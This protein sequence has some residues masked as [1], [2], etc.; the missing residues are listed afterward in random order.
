[1]LALTM[2][3]SMLTVI[4]LANPE[5]ADAATVISEFV[6]ADRTVELPSAMANLP[7]LDENMDMTYY[8]GTGTGTDYY[9]NDGFYGFKSSYSDSSPYWEFVAKKGAAI[10]SATGVSGSDGTYYEDYQVAHSVTS[11]T[12]FMTTAEDNALIKRTFNRWYGSSSNYLASGTIWMPGVDDIAGHEKILGQVYTNTASTYYLRDITGYSSNYGGT[13]NLAIV[14]SNASTQSVSWV[15]AGSTSSLAH[16]P[17]P[18]VYMFDLDLSKVLYMTEC[19]NSVSSPDNGSFSCV[20]N[21]AATGI[22]TEGNYSLYSDKKA[23]FAIT[24]LTSGFS[25]SINQKQLENAVMAGDRLRYGF[26]YSG[27]TTSHIGGG[28]LYIAADIY[29]PDDELVYHG[30]L[31]LNGDGNFDSSTDT[32]TSSSGTAYISFPDDLSFQTDGYKLAVYELEVNSNTSYASNMSAS[33]FSGIGYD[34]AHGSISIE[35]GPETA[36]EGDTVTA[37]DFTAAFSLGDTYTPLFGA[38]EGI[39]E[40]SYM[41]E[42]GILYAVSTSDFNRMF[43]TTGQW[44]GRQKKYS[45]SPYYDYIDG[46]II[47][48]S[49]CQTFTSQSDAPVGPVALEDNGHGYAEVTLFI[50]PYPQ[51][52]DENLECVL[53]GGTDIVR[54][55]NIC[56]PLEAEDDKTLHTS[57]S[58]NGDIRWYYTTDTEITDGKEIT[59]ATGVYTKQNDISS[60]IDTDNVLHVPDTI[61]DDTE[62]DI[63]VRSIGGGSTDTP[64]V[65]A[66]NNLFTSIDFGNSCQKIEEGALY[67]STA[68]LNLDIPNQIEFI[69][70]RA[71]SGMAHLTTLRITRTDDSGLLIGEN[72]FRG[73]GGLI[74][75]SLDVE[76]ARISTAAFADNTSLKAVTVSGNST[77]IGARCFSGDTALTAVNLKGM[78][79][80]D[81]GNNVFLGDSALSSVTLSDSDE[82]EHFT[83]EIGS[84]AF[85]GCAAI[86]KLYIP[87]GT[88]LHTQ[89]FSGCKGIK[90]LEFNG[91]E[92]SS[93][94]FENCTG[95]TDLILGS[96]VETVCCDWGGYSLTD[97]YTSQEYTNDQAVSTDIVIKN[98][99]TAMLYSETSKTSLGGS[100]DG[101]YHKSKRQITF[102]VASADTV[103]S[104]YS[105]GSDTGVKIG[106]NLLSFLSGNSLEANLTADGA[107][108]ISSVKLVNSYSKTAI[109]EKNMEGFTAYYDGRLFEDDSLDPDRFVITSVYSDGSLGEKVTDFY[110]YD[111]EAFDTALKDYFAY[112]NRSCL[113]SELKTAW[114]S[115][116]N[117]AISES[118][119]AILS[120]RTE[121]ESMLTYSYL[122][123][124]ENYDADSLN[125][126]NNLKAASLGGGQSLVQT[127]GIM[128][129]TD[130]SS[131]TYQT[132]EASVLVTKKTAYDSVLS[133]TGSSSLAE[134]AE[135]VAKLADDIENLEKQVD[136][137]YI[138]ASAVSDGNGG[139]ATETRVWIS[140]TENAVCTQTSVPALSADGTALTD[141]H[142]DIIYICSA[143]DSQG[144][145][146]YFY[147]DSKGVHFTDS[148]GSPTGETY[149]VTAGE[150][151]TKL[152]D[153]AELCAELTT[154]TEKYIEKLAKYTETY[155]GLVD[156]L[157]DILGTSVVPGS[158]TETDSRGKT[159]VWLG[160]EASDCLEYTDML[161][162][163]NTVTAKDENGREIE[164]TKIEIAQKTDGTRVYFYIADDGIYFTDSEG[165]ATGETYTDSLSIIARQVASQLSEVREH[166]SGTNEKLAALQDGLSE[167]AESLADYIDGYTDASFAALSDSEKMAAVKAAVSQVLEDYDTVNDSYARIMH[168]IYGD[169]ENISEKSVD[170]TIKTIETLQSGMAS[171]C[172]QI[173]SILTG[174]AV[175]EDDA[176]TLAALLDAVDEINT[177]LADKTQ[178]MDDIKS[179]IDVTNDSDV[180]AKIIEMRDTISS[181]ESGGTVSST[182]ATTL[183]ASIGDPVSDAGE[184][185]VSALDA[186]TIGEA[187]VSDLAPENSGVIAAADVEVEG[188]DGSTD[189]TFTIPGIESD[190]TITVLHKNESTGVWESLETASGEDTVTATFT[191]F[192]PVVIL[193]TGSGAA[194]I[195]AL[196]SENAELKTQLENASAS[197]TTTVNNYHSSSKSTDSSAVKPLT[198]EVEK[199][200][201]QVTSLSTENATLTEQNAT[202]TEKNS[203]LTSENE[204]LKTRVSE[205]EKTQTVTPAVQQTAQSS[206][207][208]TTAKQTAAG[209]TT[210]TSSSTVKAASSSA[211]K[212]SSSGSASKT[213]SS[214]A[215]TSGTV[216]SSSGNVQA[217]SV[218]AYEP[219]EETVACDTESVNMFASSSV[220]GTTK[221][222][223]VPVIADFP[224][225]FI[226]RLEEGISY[227]GSLVTNGMSATDTT[228]IQKD[229]ANA[230]FAYYAEHPEELGEETGCQELVEAAS[231]D[232]VTVE[233]AAQS[234]FDII[235]SDAQ[236]EA[237]SS[238]NPAEV[239][240][241]FDGIEDGGMY[242]A[243]HESSERNE[244]D[245][246]LLNAEDGELSFELEDLSPV[247]IASIDF[248]NAVTDDEPEMLS[249]DDETENSSGLMKALAVVL[250]IAIGG[251]ML[252]I[253]KKRGMFS[254]RK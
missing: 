24:G 169:N 183:L 91:E 63:P 221:L 117:T 214:S 251:I 217:Q 86:E 102:Y 19:G 201:G 208:G 37:D 118:S 31:D 64:F 30:L 96:G 237:I 35:K 172:A 48:N 36:Y 55:Q 132:T 9:T 230:I 111:P 71:F 61:H 58:Y 176:R 101:G 250:V 253:M 168:T 189:V 120:D 222:S 152:A 26:T 77:E 252:Y 72:A 42:N 7:E 215:S 103:S 245:I 90:I 78:T 236:T 50:Y 211:A 112:A 142:G 233:V 2:A 98:P 179:V 5:R 4:D 154:K 151:R 147:V 131:G 138:S 195:N 191:D 59:V 32:V 188:A 171:V 108:S 99:D 89:A 28:N 122:E 15:W 8:Y 190:D 149:S 219:A 126:L 239:T 13:S 246:V 87:S 220:I 34:S 92:L 225:N 81:I 177:S 232:S 107:V 104:S 20:S 205:L 159:Y 144:N 164:G 226:K 21:S 52:T 109:E 115:A 79:G 129:Y 163:G 241:S 254:F 51:F 240:V 184:V 57:S 38:H 137:I 85:S 83:G 121:F 100:S 88:S 84:F 105:S 207:T 247:S 234:G 106:Y 194:R 165:N 210:K 202:L 67:K 3:V 23:A 213:A 249:A 11:G 161:S 27:A 158:F 155:S 187:V 146:V 244:F 199:L 113:Y 130:V 140:D 56:I 181:Y 17:Y 212:T 41:S 124:D 178:I 243:V 60:I 73:D 162:D 170:S 116:V 204:D 143:V 114:V 70:S 180:L 153:S 218:N 185:S 65:P 18:R 136:G 248:V 25:T 186:A 200:T 134:V 223:S 16:T 196:A 216:S 66:D 54:Y 6:T 44:T 33:A 135:N 49:S 12:N 125:I 175:S 10:T 46:T 68:F 231:D 1:M 62:G 203:T 229:E 235:P 45:Q 228:A 43:D 95:I 206:S 110:Y 76:N 29:S 39:K 74:T 80:A 139:T 192:S 166:I 198:E 174:S 69:G 209:S 75:V 47:N 182:M 150:L 238:G 156:T 119:D 160:T 40:E 133:D 157:N 94:A 82:T 224:A 141:S 128:V 22:I 197:G 53:D 167:L 145:T 97:I 14:D 193:K 123:D 242:L 148:E 127:V 93:L 227:I 173:D